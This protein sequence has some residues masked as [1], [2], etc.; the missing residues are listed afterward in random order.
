MSDTSEKNDEWV[1]TSKA[2]RGR[3]ILIYFG[4]V[5]HEMFFC[6]AIFKIFV[7]HLLHGLARQ[8]DI[9]VHQRVRAEHASLRVP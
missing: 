9:I 3:Q 1:L 7:L 6:N 2:D 5:R 4:D 8:A